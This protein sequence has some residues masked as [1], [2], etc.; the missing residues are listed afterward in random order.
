[1]GDRKNVLGWLFGVVLLGATH[2]A[3]SYRLFGV[4]YAW[5]QTSPPPHG[6]FVLVT[7]VFAWVLLFPL[8]LVGVLDRWLRLP[9]TAYQVGFIIN[10]LLWS[11]GFLLLLHWS[12]RWKRKS[13]AAS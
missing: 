2:L 9:D 12:S 4:L 8:Y 13:R 11:A 1:M 7:R 10:S 5:G 6:P 3:I